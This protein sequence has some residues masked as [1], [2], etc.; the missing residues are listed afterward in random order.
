M[1]QEVKETKA[2]E[3]QEGTALGHDYKKSIVWNDDYTAATGTFTCSRCDFKEEIPA[4]V[5]SKTTDPT[6]T[7]AG[8]TTVSA[9]AE[10][11]DKDGKVIETV[12]DSKVTETI[13]A[14][15]HDYETKFDW[16]E[17]G[18]SAKLT[19]TRPAPIMAILIF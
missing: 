16:A 13:P 6:C 17:D 7:E 10:L 18:S 12:E 11:K 5:T 2:A 3:V 1:G 8:E 14:T 9:K 4:E 19:P 15:G